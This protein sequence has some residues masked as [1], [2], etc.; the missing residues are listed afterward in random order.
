MMQHHHNKIRFHSAV[1]GALAGGLVAFGALFFTGNIAVPKYVPVGSETFPPPMTQEEESTIE[2]VDF[3]NPAVVNITISRD[4]AR[5][6]NFNRNQ[7]PFDDF[8]GF[9]APLEF[10]LPDDENPEPQLREVGGGSGVIIDASGLVVTNKHVVSDEE[11]I[12]TV[13]LSDGTEYEA[14]VLAK[15]PVLDLALIKIDGSDLPT[16]PL[17]DSDAIRPGQSV[18]AIGNALAEFGNTV[19]RG[20]VSGVG[21][22]VQAGDGR[23]FSEVLDQ[24]IQ[25]D[26]AINPGNSGGPLLNLAGQV[27]GINTA[28]SSR[29]QSVGF[30]IPINAAKKTIESVQENGRIIRP[31]IGVRYIPVTPRLAEENNLG[32]TY[33][34][35]IAGGASPEAPAVISGSPADKA[36]LAAN[37]IVLEINGEKLEDKDSLAVIISRYDVG[38]TISLLVLRDGEQKERIITLEEFPI[39]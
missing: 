6:R 17:G 34:A 35:L 16:L 11:A 30:A 4:V 27:I 20:V 18:I 38:D 3:A 7:F 31:W 5:L 13:T 28:V 1:V 14:Q 21:R 37:D 36:G 29:G 15:D 24:A 12:F 39:E 23:G 33:G 25:T 26:A 10:T 32:V 22:R 2:V 19:T 9:D 8:F